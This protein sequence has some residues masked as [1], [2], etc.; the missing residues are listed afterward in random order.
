[1]YIC[2]QKVLSSSPL[3]NMPSKL[4]EELRIKTS[5]GKHVDLLADFISQVA[6]LPS[7]QILCILMENGAVAL[8]QLTDEGLRNPDAYHY[9]Q[10]VHLPKDACD[11]ATSVAIQPLGHLIAIGIKHSGVKIIKTSSIKHNMLISSGLA[12]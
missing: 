6:Y 4:R 7:H 9:L 1:M 8:A 11:V 10:W 2:L 3:E 5:G 12:H